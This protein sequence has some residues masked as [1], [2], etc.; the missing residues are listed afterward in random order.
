M[1]A[2]IFIQPGPT[3]I[4]SQLNLLPKPKSNHYDHVHIT[5]LNHVDILMPHVHVLNK[6]PYCFMCT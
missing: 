2:E 1:V 4:F 6:R 3:K 5:Y